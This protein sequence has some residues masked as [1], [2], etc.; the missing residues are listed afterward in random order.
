MRF[1]KRQMQAVLFIL[2]CIILYTGWY[3]ADSRAEE[4]QG[5]IRFHVLANSNSDEDQQLKLKVRD[6]VLE[7]V[8]KKLVKETVVRHE[9]NNFKNVI[10]EIGE[11]EPAAE[12]MADVSNS[13][14]SKVAL[15]VDESR[16]YLENNLD[17]I[18]IIAEDII[19][20]N[21]YDYSVK[22]ELGVRWIPEKTYGD[23][24]FPA[25]NYEALNITIGAGEGDNWWCVLFP[26]LCLIDGSDD[27]ENAD[28]A[29]VGLTEEL[30]QLRKGNKDL[31]T[32]ETALKLKFKTLELL[33]K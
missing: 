16:E 22:A 19:R 26:P 8:N 17:V 6:G 21:G 32:S 7:A 20:E 9:P 1:N 28:S 3:A 14:T 27:S 15:N 5:I 12:T 4:H 24:T 11:D 13:K 31:I 18:E 2:I 10:R 29:A 33:N 23:M 25:G 30:L